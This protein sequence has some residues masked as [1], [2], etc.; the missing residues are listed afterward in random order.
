L[1]GSKA[2]GSLQPAVGVAK[3]LALVLNGCQAVGTL[4]AIGAY[5]VVD[6]DVD[7]QAMKH[8][9]LIPQPSQLVM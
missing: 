8:G 3:V 6:A 4:M 2:P 9:Y 5:P 1:S 7:Q